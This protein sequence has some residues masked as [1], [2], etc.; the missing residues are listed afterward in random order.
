MIGKKYKFVDL[1]T[2]TIHQLNLIISGK[3]VNV[4]SNNATKKVIGKPKAQKIALAAAGFEKEDIFNLSCEVDDS[5]AKMLYKVVF[6]TDLDEYVY[7]I[8]IYSGK[9]K[10]KWKEK[11]KFIGIERAKEIALEI[12]E[13]TLKRLEIPHEI[14]VAP[15]TI[16]VGMKTHGVNMIFSFFYYNLGKALAREDICREGIKLAREVL[17]KF[18]Q[19]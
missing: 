10:N 2:L 7:E 15:Y 11:G 13:D 17:D 14:K 9:I 6:D 4:Y 12:Y 5:G 16:P 18:Y 19:K 1:A 3:D 8:D